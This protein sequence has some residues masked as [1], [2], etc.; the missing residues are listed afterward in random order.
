MTT[1]E[2]GNK[3]IKRTKNKKDKDGNDVLEE[4]IIDSNG[5]KQIVRVIK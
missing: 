5:N 1:D 3:I 4:E 2:L